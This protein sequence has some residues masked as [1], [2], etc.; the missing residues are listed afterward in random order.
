MTALDVATELDPDQARAVAHP[1]AGGSLAI[2]GPA[3]SGKTFALAYRAR[4]LAAEGRILVTAPSDFGVARL[5]ERLADVPGDVV[6]ESVGDAAFA[7]LRQARPHDD[8]EPIDDVRAALHFE[9]AGA[10][11]FA[12]EWTEFVSAEIDP[13]ITGLR[14]PERFSAAAF[15][16]IRKLRASLISPEAFKAAGLRGAASFYAN[17]PNLASAD[18]IMETSAKYRDSLRVTPDEL[19]RQ[20]QREVD[21]VKILARLYSA[22]VETLVAHGC[23]TPTDAV[24]EATLLL[25]ARPDFRQPARARF[26]ALLVDDAQDLTSAQ[27]GFL[28][29]LA[30]DALANVTFAGDALQ[31]TRGFAGGGRGIERLQQAAHAVALARRDRSAPAIERAACIVAEVAPPADLPDA[32]ESIPSA[33]VAL[34][35]AENMRDE[36]RYVASEV[37]RLRAGGTPASQ[38]AVVARNVRCSGTYVDALLARGIPVDVAGMASLYDF[39]AV[40]DALAAL[41][42]TVDPY[43]HD[44]LLRALQAPW[45]A[46]SDATLAVLCADSAEPQPLLFELPEEGSADERGRRWD[47]R[48]NV[49][50]GRNVTRGDVDADLP[51]DARERLAAFR[52]GLDRWE[53]LARTC[54]AAEL[55]RIV[56]D[57]TV[58]ATLR[59]DARGRFERHLVAR[60]VDEIEAQVARDALATLE[61]VL[62]HLEYVAAAEDDLLALGLR[63]PSAV[64]MLD[65]EAAKGESFSAVFVVD[66]RAGAWPR[67]YVPDA[68]LF[69]P[70]A[71]MIPKENVGDARAA[72]TA[73]FTYA[74][75]RHRLR[76]KYHRE[77]RRALYTA[78]VRAKDYLSLSTSGRATRG[79]SAP[80]FF[81]ELRAKLE[82]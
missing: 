39:P 12:L 56:L 16:L 49:R 61:D 72:R 19:E 1:R 25:R 15:R 78:M 60:L 59:D 80:E 34:Y 67:Y 23:F 50:L 13:E 58:L 24:Y 71:G 41:W 10:E 33:N 66:V 11:L 21:L 17:P 2:G 43:R 47:R 32:A 35:R 70:S 7:V 82:H 40:G 76:E 29:A 52:V 37:A 75:F 6:C 3:G 5:R 53:T 73:K 54:D 48:R 42:S 46:L 81:E 26:G 38:I 45:L 77:D 68:F 22:Y 31:S 18:L 51:Q 14:A 30:D 55:A 79:A 28:E 27:S 63:D 36:A 9:R 4:R 8:L 44:Y 69:L 20:R 64:R 65:V 74:L 62:L 57:E